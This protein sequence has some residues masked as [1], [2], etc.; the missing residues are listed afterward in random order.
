MVELRTRTLLR[1]LSIVIAVA[2]TLEVVWIAREVVAWIVIS[3]F[4]ALALDPLVGLIQRRLRLGAR[5]GDR[6][7]L[8]DRR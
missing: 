7:R 8:P 5:C 3:L 4:L 6:R 1:V 2:V